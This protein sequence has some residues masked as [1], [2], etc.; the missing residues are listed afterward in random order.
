MLCKFKYFLDIR[1][2][3]DSIIIITSITESYDD[4]KSLDERSSVKILTRSL[5]VRPFFD[6]TH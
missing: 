4:I 2:L 5:E 3:E 1:I 6:G